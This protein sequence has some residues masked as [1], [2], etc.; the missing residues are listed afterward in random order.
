MHA[1]LQK[2]ASDVSRRVAKVNKAKRTKSSVDTAID[3][4]DWSIIGDAIKQDLFDQFEHSAKSEHSAIES[5]IS[6]DVFSEH[7]KAYSD[8]RSAELVTDIS[9][10]TRKALRTTVADAIK[11]GVTNKQLASTIMDSF[12]FSEERSLMIARTELA[13]ADVQGHL[14]VSEAA[15]A[16]GKRWLLS[17]DHDFDDECTDNAEEDVI[18]WDDDWASGDDAPPSHPNCECDFEA[19]YADDPD[20]EDLVDNEDDDDSAK[21]RKLQVDAA[22]HQAATSWSNYKDAPSPAQIKAG[23]YAMGHFTIAGLDITVENPAGSVRRGTTPDGTPWHSELTHHYG[24]VKRTIG[25]DGDHVD[26]LVRQ[27]MDDEYGGPVFVVDQFIDGKF[28]EHKCLLGWD[29]EMA[30]R[31]AYLEQYQ[32]GWKGLQAI[33]QFTIEEF[34][35][36]LKSGDMTKP[37]SV[38]LTNSEE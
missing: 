38:G 21:V 10:T 24:Y 13:M 22:A 33:T 2:I 12:Q 35:S 20:A 34:K 15:G 25:A 32:V 7:A 8:E 31:N 9:S 6:F 26:I 18:P 37:V 4:A 19:I 11:E 1:A 36:W 28:D 14:V 29:T 27:G 30:A 16:V 5:D 23:N 3:N 17:N